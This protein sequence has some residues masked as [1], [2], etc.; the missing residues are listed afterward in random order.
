MQLSNTNW[1]ENDI[2]RIVT[3]LRHIIEEQKFQ[4]KYKYLYF[5]CNWVLHP[6][7][8]KSS[9]AF[10]ILELLTDSM[11]AHNKN[12]LKGKWINDAIIEGLS[13]HKL[14]ID[15]IN[16]CKEI[17][18]VNVLEDFNNWKKFALMLFCELIDKPIRFPNV[19]NNK[20][21]KDFYDSIQKK[22][23]NID[24]AVLG[25][26][27][28]I[29]NNRIFWRIYTKTSIEKNLRVIGPMAIINQEMIDKYKSPQQ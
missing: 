27:F 14:Q 19:I 28:T 22:A 12:P 6:E 17:H 7:I 24:D 10:E 9:T 1:T 25:I 16:L 8:S 21:I 20:I 4:G 2:L 29:D 23:K 18:V 26:S 5:Y 13:I 3:S 15:I 11:I